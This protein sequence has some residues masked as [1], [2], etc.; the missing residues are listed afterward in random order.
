[1]P[2]PSAPPARPLPAPR[3]GSPELLQLAW[4]GPDGKVLSGNFYW[5]AEKESD[6]QAM[7]SMAAAKIEGRAVVKSDV[8]GAKVEVTVRNAA[9]TPA[10]L[11]RVVARHAKDG[12]RIL[13]AFYGD[14][15]FSLL[16][17]EERSFTADLP[18][19]P[20]AAAVRIEASGWNSPPVV[21]SVGP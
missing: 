15:Y 20:A 21:L 6:L 10:L 14:N 9:S 17:G 13:P 1:M 7:A 2:P 3:A 19:V 8:G 5:R 4:V 16:P 12:T 11:I 18:G